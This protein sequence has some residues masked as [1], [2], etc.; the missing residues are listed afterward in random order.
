MLRGKLFAQALTEAQWAVQVADAVLALRRGDRGGRPRWTSRSVPMLLGL[1]ETITE[2]RRVLVERRGDERNNYTA[3]LNAAG[4]LRRP[5][6]AGV[7]RPTDTRLWT[8]WTYTY[9]PI[10]VGDDGWEWEGSTYYHLFVLRAYLLGLRASTRESCPATSSTGSPRWSACWSSCST[11]AG[12]SRRCTTVPTTAR[13]R[14][15]EVLEICVLAGQLRRAGP[16]SPA[17][18][19]SARH[20]R[21]STPSTRGPAGRTGSRRRPV[22]VR[23]ASRASVAVPPDGTCGYWCAVPSRRLH[24]VLDAGPHGGSHGHLDKLALYLYGE[25]SPGSRRRGY[26]RTRVRC[27]RH[28]ARRWPTRRCGSTTGTRRGDRELDRW[29]TSRRRRAV[30]RGRSLPRR[31]APRNW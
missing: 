25:R 27:A 24:A 4:R 16:A 5:R 12:G 11:E 9:L 30:A 14:T 18:A 29:S 10:A 13:A 1:L 28:Y 20:R 19:D 7:R 17:E 6:P 15:Q 26:R 31:H 2:A 22:A 21:G 23:P 3:W 8:E